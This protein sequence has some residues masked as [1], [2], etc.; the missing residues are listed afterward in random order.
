VPQKNK[1]RFDSSLIKTTKKQYKKMPEQLEK[2][3]AVFI[4]KGW[5]VFWCLACPP[6][7]FFYVLFADSAE[8]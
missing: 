6:I 7:A 3:K 1:K 5:F 4:K 2:R 8:V